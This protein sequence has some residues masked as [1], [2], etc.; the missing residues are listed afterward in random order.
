MYSQ[1]GVGDQ[2][3][4]FRTTHGRQARRNMF[5]WEIRE[6]SELRCDNFFFGTNYFFRKTQI[7]M[8][9]IFERSKDARHAFYP[10]LN[11]NNTDLNFFQS[12]AKKKITWIRQ[13]DYTMRVRS[14]CSSQ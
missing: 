5:S 14:K 3:F 12:M 1:W 2:V 6:R 4:C 13:G 11:N 7:S 9:R 8:F 10:S